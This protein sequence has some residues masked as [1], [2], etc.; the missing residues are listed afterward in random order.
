MSGFLLPPY[1]VY[2]GWDEEFNKPKTLIGT[3]R[4]FRDA[5]EQFITAVRGPDR[6]AYVLNRHGHEIL[7]MEV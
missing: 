6:Q 4:K 2:V 7:K 3:H 5:A 1:E